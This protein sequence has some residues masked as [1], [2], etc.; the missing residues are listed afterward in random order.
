MSHL[1]L[2]TNLNNTISNYYYY[3]IDSYK[4]QVKNKLIKKIYCFRDFFL[5]INEIKYLNYK[6]VFI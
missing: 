2:N 3:N 5:T 1:I 4:I 6:F